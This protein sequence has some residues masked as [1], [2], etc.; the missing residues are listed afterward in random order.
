MPAVALDVQ[1]VTI[2]GTFNFGTA[3]DWPFVG[4]RLCASLNRQADKMRVRVA[5]QVKTV[6]NSEETRAQVARGVRAYLDT[7][8]NEPLVSVRSI[9]MAQGQITI[10]P[11]L[12]R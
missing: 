5:Q 3:C 9:S 6:L 8:L 1:I 12:G 7:V 11:R 10:T 2:G 4:A